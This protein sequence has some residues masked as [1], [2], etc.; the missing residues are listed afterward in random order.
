MGGSFLL[1]P[2]S[3]AMIVREIIKILVMGFIFFNKFLMLIVVFEFYN[4]LIVCSEI[5]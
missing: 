4:W 3:K 1:H 5:F 2:E